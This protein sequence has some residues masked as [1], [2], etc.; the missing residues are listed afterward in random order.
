MS[1]DRDKQV[2]WQERSL[3]ELAHEQKL[4]QSTVESLVGQGADLWASDEELDQFIASIQERR[5]EPSAT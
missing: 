2:L 4:A 1:T 3:D 5:H